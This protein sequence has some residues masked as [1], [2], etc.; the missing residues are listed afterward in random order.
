[1]ELGNRRAACFPPFAYQAML[2]ADAPELS[3][4]VDFLCRARELAA[5]LAPPE[6]RFFDPVP[7]RLTRLARRE[8]AQLLIEA[9]RRGALQDFLACWLEQIRSLKATRELR[10]QVDID[11]LDV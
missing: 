2:K 6:V 10:W 8:R 4:A 11:P 9:G 7:M 3:A 1:M 5:T